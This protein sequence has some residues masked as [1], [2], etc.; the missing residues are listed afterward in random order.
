MLKIPPEND[1]RSST[2]LVNFQDTKLIHRNL[3]HSYSTERSGRET[4]EIILFTITSKDKIT[5]NKGT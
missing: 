3:L 5:R 2:N 1:E 4:E